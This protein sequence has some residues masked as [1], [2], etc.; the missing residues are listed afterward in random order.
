MYGVVRQPQPLPAGCRLR[1]DV[2]ARYTGPYGWGG[3]KAVRLA[4]QSWYGLRTPGLVVAGALLGL[5]AA[6]AAGAAALLAAAAVWGVRG[7]RG[8]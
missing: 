1:L 5:A 6:A 3:A 4:R 8:W 7:R 2:A